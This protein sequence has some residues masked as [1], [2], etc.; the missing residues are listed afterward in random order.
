MLITTVLIK[1]SKCQKFT[2]DRSAVDKHLVDARAS[3]LLK[4]VLYIVTLWNVFKRSG[5]HI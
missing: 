3:T 1:C 2:A 4:A 5:F